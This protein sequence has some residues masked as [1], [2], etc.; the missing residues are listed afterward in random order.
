MIEVEKKCCPTEQF[1]D[2]LNNNAQKTNECI[3]YD[4]CLDFDDL[5][6]IKNDI[7]LRKR[8]EKYELKIPVISSSKKSDIYEEIEDDK[9]IL[10]KLNLNNFD[11]LME[12]SNLITHRQRFRIGN[13]HID[14]DKITSPKTNF[15]YKI[16]EIELMIE[17]PE[18]YEYA[19]QEIIKF[20]Q[21]HHIKDE[22]VNG[23]FVEFVKEY[24]Y[25]IY[26]ILQKNPHYK[27]R[28]AA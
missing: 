11:N 19:Q 26:E 5:R 3:F 13:L 10:N 2:F 20:M 12:L 28:I 9:K 6:L 4:I 25:E 27:N 21:K 7:W 14:L 18:Q 8:N 17:F 16:M 22:I 15:M 23:K 24:R 1:L